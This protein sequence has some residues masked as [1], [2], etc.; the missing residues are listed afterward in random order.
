M[1][2]DNAVCRRGN[3]KK[4]AFRR[5]IEKHINQ[6]KPSEMENMKQIM[7]TILCFYPQ[8]GIQVDYTAGFHVEAEAVPDE[9]KAWLKSDKMWPSQSLRRQVMREGALLVPKTFNDSTKTEKARRWRINFDLNLIIHDPS[10]SSKILVR[11]ILII[12]KDIKK[13]ILRFPT[14]KSYHLKLAIAW[15]MFE[16]QHKMK[17]MTNYELTILALKYLAKS[18]KTMKLPD[19]FDP[20]FNHFHR[21]KDRSYE[22]ARVAEQIEDHVKNNENFS[23]LLDNLEKAQKGFREECVMVYYN[24]SQAKTSSNMFD[25]TKFVEIISG[26]DFNKLSRVKHVRA[27]FSLTFIIIN[28]DTFLSEAFLC[29]FK[30]IQE[31]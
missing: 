18:L 5:L 28:H 14:V 1:I 19:F 26:N 11:R 6:S 23:K 24:E 21:R 22:A 13:H 12:L 17:T 15:A 2:Y 8:E 9:A 31:F 10:Y 20:D 7:E 25:P 27:G 16:N 30:I 29:L 4:M 3:L